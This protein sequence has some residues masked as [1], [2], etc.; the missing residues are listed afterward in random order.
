MKKQRLNVFLIAAGTIALVTPFAANAKTYPF[1]LALTPGI[2]VPSTEDTVAGLNLGIASEYRNLYGVS[3]ALG[4]TRAKATNHD[5]LEGGDMDGLQ[6]SVLGS[7]SRNVYGIQAGGFETKGIR[8]RG[9]Q[10]GG[11]SSISENMYGIQAAG[12]VSATHNFSE[13]SRC[14]YGLQIAGLLTFIPD[15]GFVG[16][17]MAGLANAADTIN[18]VQATVGVNYSFRC[19]G[20]QF[21]VYNY[22]E[23]LNGCQF[24]LCNYTGTLHG[25]QIGL[26]NSTTRSGKGLQVGVINL[27]GGGSKHRFMPL[28]NFVF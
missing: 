8:V 19:Q 28:L 5:E 10:T 25:T 2:Q 22:A 6:I 14:S 20:L 13:K 12:L 23:N 18:G 24:G 9:I 15:G 17:Q 27:Y 16:I 21:G 7:E 11:L 4:L 3:L 1:A 26:I